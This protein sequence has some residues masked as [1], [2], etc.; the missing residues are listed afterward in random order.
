MSSADR[1]VPWIVAEAPEAHDEATPRAS[2]RYG[3]WIADVTGVI[4]YAMPPLT[5]VDWE[6]GRLLL[7][8]DEAY[9]ENSLCDLPL[10]PFPRDGGKLRL[11]LRAVDW[12]G[13]LSPPSEI[14]LDTTRPAPP[15]LSAPAPAPTK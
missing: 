9:P 5:Y 7:G 15:A 14:V 3:A 2:L 1:D 12:A 6:G 8:R 4:D 10:F 11:G 13:N